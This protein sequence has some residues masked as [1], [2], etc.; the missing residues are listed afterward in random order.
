MQ[1]FLGEVLG[2]MIILL[3]GTGVVANVLL[4]K[5]KGNN[6]GL[7]VIASGWAF[8]VA[9]AIYATG[10]LSGAHLNPAVTIALAATGQFPW[11]KVPMYIAAQFLGAFLGAVITYLAY[12]PHWGATEDPELKLAV[13]S[14]GPAIRNYPANLLTEII[15]T[16]ILV[17]VGLSIGITK[18]A[19]TTGLNPLLWGFLVWGLGVSFGGPTGYAINPA[20]DLGPRIAHFLLPIPGKGSSD[21]G[22]SWVPVLGPIIGGLLGAFLYKIVYMG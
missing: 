6:G 20:R 21:W 7:I 9:L 10:P 2:T 4:G 14:T 8:G 3:F 13:F 17:F 16:F 12:L 18:S 11:D 19:T 5:T 22:Y 1:A 15:G